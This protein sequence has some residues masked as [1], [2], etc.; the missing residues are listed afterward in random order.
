MSQ[1]IWND[2]K[3]KKSSKLTSFT[4]CSKRSCGYSEVTQLALLML[5]HY[6]TCLS[7]R[8]NIGSLGTLGQC[9]RVSTGSDIYPHLLLLF[10]RHITK[11][12]HH[13]MP[14]VS[15]RR[16]VGKLR[17]LTIVQFSAIHCEILA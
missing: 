10:F 5:C 11:A 17:H 3:L 8:R 2:S 6:A 15:P 12:P 14:S 13:R 16:P 1:D 7:G 4:K 9:R